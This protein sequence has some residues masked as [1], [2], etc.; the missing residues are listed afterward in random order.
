MASGIASLN[1]YQRSAIAG[2]FSTAVIQQL[3]REGRSSSFSRLVKESSLCDSL[4]ESEP[5]RNVF[6]T[7]FAQLKRKSYRNEYVYKSAIAHKLMLGKHSVQTASMLTE[8][9]VGMCKADVAILNGTSTVYEI[10]SDRDNLERLPMQISEYRQVFAKINIVTGK[11]HLDAVLSNIS[12][13][14]G[15]MLL[16][17]R[18]QI[19]TLREAEENPNRIIPEVVL[20]SI[21][22]HEAIKIL[23]LL[24]VDVPNKPNTLMYQALLEIFRI[25]EPNQ[26]HKA[27]VQVL[28]DTRSSRSSLELV[29][30][31]PVS[32]KFV[33][34]SNSF[35]NTDRARLLEVMDTPLEFALKWI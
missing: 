11:K 17:D 16:N 14:I 18:Y 20:A 19:S 12:N 26:I 24:N 1:N 23:Q 9:R 3:A 5:I 8:F 22:R 10:K 25:Q 31:L 34:I 27:M 33:A 21:Q 7:A 29:K 35:R 4:D 30:S 28:K 13:D 32:L 6:D 15:V 2:L